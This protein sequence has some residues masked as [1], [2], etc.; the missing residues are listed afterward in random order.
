MIQSSTLLS[1]LQR[2]LGTL[3][4]DLRT[5]VDTEPTIGEPLRGE[6]RSAFDAERTAWTF[7]AWAED[8]LT[9]VAVGWLLAS[10]FVRFGEDNHLID[11]AMMAGTGARG[12]EARAA[13]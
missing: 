9:Q 8:R 13:Q 3:L 7:T 1:T 2:R 6:Y 12:A 11:D 10:V 4:D 5:R